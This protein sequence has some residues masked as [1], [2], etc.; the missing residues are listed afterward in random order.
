MG[1]ASR[2]LAAVVIAAVLSALAQPAHA[3][4]PSSRHG[5]Q[6]NLG[7]LS[8][9]SPLGPGGLNGSV[10]INDNGTALV[11]GELESY[12][13]ST[14]ALLGYFAFYGGSFYSGPP[15]N[16]TAFSVQLNSNFNV[17]ASMVL[18]AQDAFEVYYQDGYYYVYVVDNLWNSTGPSFSLSPS[19]VEGSGN[20]SSYGGQ[21]YY[22]SFAESD[23]EVVYYE[24]AAPF[25][26]YAYMTLNLS[27]EGYPQVYMYYRFENST[28][29]SGWV[30]Y[31]VITVAV[32]SSNPEFLTGLQPQAPY[33]QPFV[34]QW[35]VCG[36]GEGSELYVYSWNASMSLYYLYN[37]SPFSVP[38]AVSVEPTSFEGSVTAE[39]VSP[40]HGIAERYDAGLGVVV[41]SP[42]A[43]EQEFLWSPSVNYTVSGDNLTL[44]LTPAGGRWLVQVSGGGR[45]LSYITRRG[46]ISITL[47]SGDYEVNATLY[48]GAHAVYSFVRNVTVREVT[49]LVYSPVPFTVNG[50]ERPGGL[51]V[52]QVPANVSFPRVYYAGGGVRF[53]L[54]YLLV[55][56]T[57]APGASAYLTAPSNVTA[58]YQEQ[59]YVSVNEPVPAQVDGVNTTLSSGWYNSSTMIVIPRVRQVGDDIRELIRSNVTQLTL[60]GPTSIEVSE[61][62]EYYVY[63]ALPNGTISGWYPAGYVIDLPRAIYVGGLE[64]FSINQSRAVVVSAPINATPRYVRQYYV[65]VTLPNGTISGWYDAGAVID[66]PQ[67]IY[68]GDERFVLGQAGSLVISGPINV[69]PSYTRQ[70]YVYVTLPN[71]TISGWYPA[72]SSV[73]VPAVIYVGA[74]ER[75]VLSQPQ[76]VPVVGPVNMSPLYVRQYLV[77]IDGVSR[78]VNAGSSVR[79][80][81]P[82]TP[83]ESVVWVGN[84]TLPNNSTVAVDGPIVERSVVRPGLGAIALAASLAAVAAV[85]AALRRRSRRPN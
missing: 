26:L 29:D 68:E 20:F 69:T 16:S 17:T 47:P 14:R 77:T 61:S 70:Y 64:R 74:G 51:H 3:T 66:L 43:N 25:Y 22:Y 82:A 8:A 54:D 40:V 48:A 21:E 10:G 35:V 44:R 76:E 79:L 65:V 60:T 71:G 5:A 24:T 12:G 6:A 38:S 41:Q 28:Y 2:L 30:L 31:D 39:G 1:A 49:A 50:T 18:W 27:P 56:G 36:D 58:V 33:S 19:L 83:L 81:E 62:Y 52:V 85:A 55:N 37:G 7:G 23:G 53:V 84:Y 34:T 11:G 59:F 72:G 80:Y 9:P 46:S 67:V 63:I 45:R 15:V 32:R 73:R 13:Y 57:R 4:T 75:F 78:W 42:G